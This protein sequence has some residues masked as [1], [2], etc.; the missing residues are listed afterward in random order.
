MIGYWLVQALEAASPGRRAACLICRTMV[1]ADDPAFG[2]PTKVVGPVCPEAQARRLAAEHGWQI[3]PDGTAWRRVRGGLPGAGRPGRAGIIEALAGR[4]VI[5]VCAGD[6]GIPVV[7]DGSGL[8][9]VEAVVDKDLAAALLASTVQCRP[10][11][12]C[13]APTCRRSLRGM[14]P[15][16]PDPPLGDRDPLAWATD[17][18]AGSMGPKVE[19]MTATDD[20][21]PQLPWCAA[22]RPC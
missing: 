9:G 6:G 20:M 15:R 12:C 17:F 1:K 5:G 18:P 8:R 10:T 2:Q 16:R 22:R 13:C 3:R 4:G 7:T 21:P 19:A 14:A 11:R